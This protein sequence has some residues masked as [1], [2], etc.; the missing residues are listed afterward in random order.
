MTNESCWERP[1]FDDYEDQVDNDM[2][3]EAVAE[4][5]R[6]RIARVQSPQELDNQEVL[7]QTLTGLDESDLKKLV[8]TRRL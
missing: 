1:S 5:S 7:D 8:R 4:L 3:T 6:L 2:D